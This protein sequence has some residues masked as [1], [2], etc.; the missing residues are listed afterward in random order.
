MNILNKLTIKNLKLN[1]K[2]TIGTIIGIILSVA[3]ICATGGLFTSFQRTLVENAIEES[4]YNHLTLEG[5]NLEKYEEIKLHKNVEN[6]DTIYML[7]WAE[8]DNI[9]KETTP[10]IKVFSTDRKSFDNLQFDVTEGRFPIK[11]DEIVVGKRVLTNGNLKIGDTIELDVGKR[12][13]AEGYELSEHNPYNGDEYP[14]HIENPVHHT[15]KI[16]GVADKL[17]W[18]SSYFAI[19]VGDVNNENIR[20]FVALKNPKKYKTTREEINNDKGNYSIST[21][22]E[23]LRWE[24]FAF[25]DSTITMLYTICGIVIGIIMI[26][27]IFCI[28]NSFEI[29]IIEKM[30]MYGMLASVGATKKQIKKSVI[31][32]GMILGL[33]GIPLGIISGLFADVVLIKIVNMLIGPELF[34]TDKGI[35]LKFSFGAILLAVVLGLLVIYFSSIKS[36][37][38]ASKVSPIDNLRSSN[39][40]KVTK[41]GLK[42]P[43]FISSIFK[44]GGVLAYKNLKRSKKKYRTTVISLTV[45]VFVFIAMNAFI[46]EAFVSSADYY[47]DY[48]YNLTV[49]NTRNNSI[50]DDMIKEI[51][52]TDGVDEYYLLYDVREALIVDDLSHVVKYENEGRDMQNIAIQPMSLDDKTFRDYVKR[53]GIDYDYAKDKGIVYNVFRY[54]DEKNDKNIEG[55]RFSYKKGDVIEGKIGYDKQEEL[56]ITVGGVTKTAPYGLE[57]SYYHGGYIVFNKEYFE[58]KFD[59]TL[60]HI[61]IQTEDADKLEVNLQKLDS[62]LQIMNIDEYVKSQKSM[63]LIV[64]IFLYGFITVITLIGVT[65]I[66]NTITANMELRSREFAILK[67]VGMTKGEFNRMINLET[68]FYSSKSLIYGIVLGLI[69]SYAIH[70]SFSENMVRA[71][72]PPVTAILISIVFVFLIVYIIMRYSIH[73]INKQNTI[74]TIRS[75]NI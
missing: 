56:S 27:S 48:E 58:E 46:N 71:Y 59:W 43:G 4:G 25:S 74:E 31:T 67:S 18:S 32:E 53:L 1:K 50:R 21:N 5:I 24:I 36:A 51:V 20:A 19:T 69:G 55:D 42:T 47:T 23:L 54:Y 15:Y 13:N 61:L 6:I 28:R 41:K 9:N 40:I 34:Q 10:Y 60:E 26:T 16:V 35:V 33:I 2:R 17:Y 7:G 70:M 39:E 3:L 22:S 49:R 57:N 68:L 52:S 37:R 45:S 66:F 73:K 38:K 44:T 29:S 72:T 12:M 11:N 30:R 63:I 64:S 75:E 14:E 62:D 65:N 8:F